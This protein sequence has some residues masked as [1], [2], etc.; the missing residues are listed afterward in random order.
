MPRDVSPRRDRRSPHRERPQRAHT[1]P[2]PDRKEKVTPR[3]TP[4]KAKS[5]PRNS[6]PERSE[7]KSHHQRQSKQSSAST[8]QR[9]SNVLNLESLSKLDKFNAKT[10]QEL[11]EQEVKDAK[12][13][14]KARQKESVVA[15]RV[16]KDRGKQKRRSEHHEKRRVVSGPLAEEGRVR[17]HRG[18]GYVDEKRSQKR[19]FGKKFWLITLILLTIVVILI[20]VVAV[21]VNKKKGGGSGAGG[22]NS[23]GGDPKN[24]NLQDIDSSSIPAA[25]KGGI[26]DP[27]SW[28]D[29][30]DF[31]LTY[32]D[33]KVGGLPVMGLDSKWDDSKRANDKVPPLDKPWAYGT[34]PIR[35]VNVGGWLSIEPFIT[36]SLFSSFK[37]SQGIIDEYTL[38][39]Q[40]GPE[41]AKTTL[42]KHYAQ[43]INKQSFKDI[44][45]AGFDHVRIPY[46]YWAVKTYEGDPYVSQVAW[47]YL[48]RGIEYARQCGLRV[49][50]DLHGLPGSQNGWNHSGRQGPI[51]WLNGTDGALNGQRSLDIHG[52]LSAFFA[53]PRY[54][55]V[56]A[57]YGLA[58]EPK[59]IKLDT[60]SV[61]TWT[62][63]AVNQV[64]KNGIKQ[65]I[66][67]GDGFLGL[68]KWQGKLQGLQGL[69]L[70]SHPYTIFNPQQIVFTHQ[71]KISYACTDWQD[72]QRTSMDTSTG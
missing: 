5:R 61:L 72:Q 33:E 51:G 28:Y 55:N 3:N 69:V 14:R 41:K 63:N 62:T 26:L 18:G 48:L 31:N 24:S 32:T 23:D 17:R 54:K 60:N 47:R 36:P 1:R 45:E 19:R 37:S 46:S 13:E 8:T 56:I 67:I 66:A 59:M 53:Q 49:N 35:G 43:F 22:G 71:K 20:A 29:T 68:P 58:N 10:A 52:Q 15:G 39:K 42:E 2:R 9:S 27:F 44:Q 16:V 4:E 21:V 64:R 50:L 70:D 34:M 11:E 30:T 12:R 38:T 40:L 25:A 65:T 57:I 7:R 6:S